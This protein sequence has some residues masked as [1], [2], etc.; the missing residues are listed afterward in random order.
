MTMNHC[1][2]QIQILFNYSQPLQNQFDL[3]KPRQNK[4]LVLKKIDDF[5]SPTK[6]KCHASEID[7]N[8]VRFSEKKIEVLNKNM[9]FR[10]EIQELR[11]KTVQKTTLIRSCVSK[12]RK[13]SAQ[14]KSAPSSSQLKN[15]LKWL[16]YFFILKFNLI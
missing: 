7:S 6:Y 13:L 16:R 12:P 9:Q 10:Y 5:G 4:K 3:L 2:R 11:S 14:K 1:Q 15:F 8:F